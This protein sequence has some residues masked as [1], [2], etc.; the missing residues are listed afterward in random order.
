MNKMLNFTKKKK[1]N[2]HH[3][4]T[5]QMSFSPESAQTLW[6]VYCTVEPG[7]PQPLT[8]LQTTN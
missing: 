8:I 3:L 1:E 6:K 4:R 7:F 2:S 5:T